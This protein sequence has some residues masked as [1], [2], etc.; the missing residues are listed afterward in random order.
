MLSALQ[1]K[2]HGRHN[3]FS[4]SVRYVSLILRG[5]TTQSE[6]YS[7]THTV[8]VYHGESNSS[9]FKLSSVGFWPS[10]MAII[11]VNQHPAFEVFVES[12]RFGIAEIFHR[13]IPVRALDHMD[14]IGISDLPSIPADTPI[15]LTVSCKLIRRN[16]WVK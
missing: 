8:K 9:Q 6:R 12:L 2:E 14:G 11:V 5:R 7:V 4:N 16:L 15:S 1:K 10:R 13:P 3:R